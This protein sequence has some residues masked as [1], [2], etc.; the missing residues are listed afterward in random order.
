MIDDINTL[1]GKHIIVILSNQM[2]YTGKVI[3]SDD[4]SISIVDKFDKSVYIV[5]SQVCSIEEEMQ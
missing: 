3:S 4:T 5:V 1:I 2:R